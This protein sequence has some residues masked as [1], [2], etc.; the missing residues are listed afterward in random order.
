[1]LYVQFPTGAGDKTQLALHKA[2]QQWFA[3]RELGLKCEECKNDRLDKDY[4]QQTPECLV[5]HLNRIKPDKG[6]YSKIKSRISMSETLQL[7]GACFDPNIGALEEKVHYELTSVIM[8]TGPSPDLGHYYMVVKGPGGKWASID[9][10]KVHQF[11]T[12]E[13][14]A[15]RSK[16]RIDA[17][18]FA[19]R[20]ITADEYQTIKSQEKKKKRSPA[21]RPRKVQDQ[22]V[23]TDEEFPPEPIGKEEEPM[24]LF[25]HPHTFKLKF[26]PAGGAPVVVNGEFETGVP[27]DTVEF[28]DTK[29]L[30]ELTWLDK[31]DNI[32]RDLNIQGELRNVIGRKP[33]KTTNEGRKSRFVEHF[34]GS[35]SGSNKSKK[36]ASSGRSAPGAKPAGIVKKRSAKKGALDRFSGLK[37][38]LGGGDKGKKKVEKEKE[39]KKK[40]E[41]KKG[42]EGKKKQEKEEKVKEKKKKQK[43]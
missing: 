21:D 4:F 19:Y 12:F 27:M 3:Q 18:M 39:E 30:L 35:G 40:G 23:Q 37:R 10:K 8:H 22:G 34:S 13:D 17:Y 32:L 25:G 9:D 43:K 28:P 42:K 20:R 14:W 15:T 26:T 16:A 5:V 6:G 36:S 29:G 38:A 41:K 11:D 33:A 24:K 1:M 7:N 2:V 31:E